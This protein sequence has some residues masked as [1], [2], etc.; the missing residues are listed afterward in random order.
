M[1]CSF[2]TAGYLLFRRQICIAGG[3]RL[4]HQRPGRIG[5]DMKPR[6]TL[7]ERDGRH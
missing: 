7:L 3:S 6:I 5:D 2:W 1:S 4:A